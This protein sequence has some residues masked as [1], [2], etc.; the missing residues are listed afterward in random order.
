MALPPSDPEWRLALALALALAL[1]PLAP[2][3]AWLGPRR[4]SPSDSCFDPKAARC[5]YL[6]AGARAVTR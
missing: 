5:Q 6:P 3:P 1:T 4:L 2:T